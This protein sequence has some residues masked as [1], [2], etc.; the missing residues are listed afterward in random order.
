[1]KESLIKVF[2]GWE[3]DTEVIGAKIIIGVLLLF[4]CFV[5]GRVSKKVFLKVNAKLLSKHPDVLILVSKIIY[6]IFLFLGYFL[7]LNVVGLEQYLTKILAGAGIVGIIAGFAL[8]DI[9]S[10]AFS[11][12]LLFLQKPYVKGDWVQLDG[13]YGKVELV[14]WLTTTLSNRTGQEIYVSNQLIYS[15][16]FMNY[17]KYKKRR[18]CIEVDVENYHDLPKLKS[19]VQAKISVFSNLLPKTDIDFYVTSV[20]VNG[21]FSFELYYWIYFDEGKKFRETVSNSIIGIQE[22]GVENNIVFKNLKWQ[23][24]E[25]DGTSAERFGVNG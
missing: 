1:M 11:G 22:I 8:K 20:E 25:E 21:N 14:G 10:N 9:A 12:L 23:S 2:K 24:D 7:F 19:L 4:V 18:V 16:T 13:H 3:F 17:S 15:G 5:A 6:Y